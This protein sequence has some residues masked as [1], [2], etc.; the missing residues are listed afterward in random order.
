[1][2]ASC[3]ESV[4]ELTKNRP[5]LLQAVFCGFVIA[6]FD[7]RLAVLFELTCV[8]ELPALNGIGGAVIAD[9]RELEG[10]LTFEV[11]E[12]RRGRRGE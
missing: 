10:H 8:E 11:H 2:N 7:L 1:M 9:V 12:L 4:G 6:G 3:L 5:R